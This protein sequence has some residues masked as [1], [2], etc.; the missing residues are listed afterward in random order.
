MLDGGDGHYMLSIPFCQNPPSLAE[1]PVL[2]EQ[3]L[4]SLRRLLIRD[5]NL[6]KAYTGF[7]DD[8]FDKGYG[9]KVEVEDVN[10]VGDKVW[11]L[12][13]HNV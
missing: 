8:L 5:N 7:M 6:H 13:H 10:K 4:E 11:Y 2:V 3:R 9:E 1:N 12:P